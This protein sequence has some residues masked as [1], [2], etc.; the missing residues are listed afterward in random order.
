MCGSSI[1]NF[2]RISG[3]LTMIINFLAYPVAM[4]FLL[5]M[6]G[7]V[8]SYP[9]SFGQV[10]V[11][12]IFVLKCWFQKN[13]KRFFFHKIGTIMMPKRIG[14]IISMICFICTCRGQDDQNWYSWSHETCFKNLFYELVA[15]YIRHADKYWIKPKML[16]LR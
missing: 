13:G 5:S 3:T 8:Y 12:V 7:K 11:F 15:C 16:V 6:Q 2:C 10:A 9:T 1:K 4:S 14:Y